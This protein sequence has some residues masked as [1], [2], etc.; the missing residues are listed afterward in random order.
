MKS[1]HKWIL[2]QIVV[3]VLAGGLGALVAQKMTPHQAAEPI[4]RPSQEHKES[5][6]ECSPEDGDKK[7][8][9]EPLECGGDPKALAADVRTLCRIYA[10]GA[11]CAYG[12]DHACDVLVSDIRGQRWRAKP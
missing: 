1:H 4:P 9:F 8:L 10:L 2:A 7:T 6:M 11:A 3:S 12:M 5:P